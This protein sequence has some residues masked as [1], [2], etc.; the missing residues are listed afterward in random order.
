MAK[1][2]TIEMCRDPLQLQSFLNA[3]YTEVAA[4]TTLSTELRTWAGTLATKLNAD[5]GVTDADYDATITA[6]APTSQA[7]KTL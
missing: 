5:G 1:K 3:L 4:N 2:I 7:T 6:T